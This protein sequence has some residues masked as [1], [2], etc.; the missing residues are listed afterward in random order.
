M[1]LGPQEP[2]HYTEVGLVGT[3]VLETLLESLATGCQPAQKPERESWGVPA[4]L[5]AKV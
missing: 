2:S 4:W 5:A 3:R 1:L